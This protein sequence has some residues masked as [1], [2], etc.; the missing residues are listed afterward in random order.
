MYEPIGWKG[1]CLL[2]RRDGTD[3]LVSLSVG[4]VED[5]QGRVIGSFGIGH[6]ISEQKR[7]EE[8]LRRSEEQ[9]RELAEHIRAVF[10]ILTP[11]PFAIT[12][13]SPAYD[14]IWGRLRQQLYDQ[15]CSRT[16]IFPRVRVVRFQ[17]I[18]FRRAMRASSSFNSTPITLRKGD[19]E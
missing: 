4:P 2:C 13:I 16:R 9:F 15:P 17:M 5:M 7:A 12:Y 14:Q 10:F 19:S 18:I 11:D 8:A 6:D 3:F 1:E